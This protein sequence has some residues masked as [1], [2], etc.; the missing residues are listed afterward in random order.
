[1]PTFRSEA[2]NDEAPGYPTRIRSTPAGACRTGASSRFYGYLRPSSPGAAHKTAVVQSLRVRVGVLSV[3]LESCGKLP[4]LLCAWL[5]ASLAVAQLPPKHHAAAAG[6]PTLDQAIELASAG[7]CG[8]ALPALK[9]QGSHLANKELAYRA[10]MAIV[11][12]AMSLGDEQTTFTALMALRRDFPKDPQVLYISAHFLSE[13]A[14]H[15]SQ[16]LMAVAPGSYQARELQAEAFE[17]ENKLDDAAE[18]YRKIVKDNP[19]TPG[20][21]YRLGRLA[22]ARPSSP[23]NAE[24]A[25]REFE[26]ELAVDPTNASAE[27]WLGEIARRNGQWDEAI[28]RF[29][30][31]AKH[32]PGFAEAF[33]GLGLTLNSAGRFLDAVTPLERYVKMV[34]GDPAGHYQLSVAYVRTGRKAE[35]TREIGIQQELTRQKDGSSAP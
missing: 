12:C 14:S 19:K 35:A 3:L 33:L 27:F 1:M 20:I 29:Q 15:A 4:V 5:L 18:V 34:P 32:D 16:E 9:R 7:Q 2:V 23:E 10:Q 30:T 13:M 21:H 17:S 8:E 6:T 31:A 22:L 24:E 11:R 28:S 26:Q 25:K